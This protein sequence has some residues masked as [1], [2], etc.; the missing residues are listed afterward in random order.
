M[1]KNKKTTIGIIGYGEVG[2]AIEK[3]AKPKYNVYC[4]DLS[5]DQIGDHPI[6]ILNLC[7]PYGPMF[8]PTAV[9]AI[10]GLKPKLVIIHSTVKPGT[11][12]S[13]YHQ[14]HIPI[15]HTPIMGVHPHLAKYQ[16]AFSKIIGAIDE[17][18]FSRVK[19]FWTNLGAKKTIRF[20]RPEESELGKI[21]CTTYYG[22]N[23]VFNKAVKQ[24]STKHKVN[25]EQIYHQINQVYNAG[26]KTTLPHVTRPDLKFVE[27]KIGGHCVLPN[28]AFMQE[29]D[30]LFEEFMRLTKKFS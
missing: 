5:F 15:A 29:Y 16:K 8:V 23:I 30:E 20:D 2:K 22:W 21:I 28:A 26:Y 12:R 3:L 14:T 13:I 9:T 24:L 27:G 1:T 10:M 18:T 7:F 6:K 19:A 4:R 25:F 17:P 11:T